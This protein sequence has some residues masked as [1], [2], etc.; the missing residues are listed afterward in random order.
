MDK[1]TILSVWGKGRI[2]SGYDGNKYR[3]DQCGAWM[4]YSEYGNR[5]SI[6]GW[7]IDHIIPKSKGGSDYISNL[8]PLQW[9][10]NRAKSDGIEIPAIIASQGRNVKNICSQ[11]LYE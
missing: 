4:V 11:I 8:Q 6:Y 3:K 10:N 7:E 5:N 9:E 2:V 1:I